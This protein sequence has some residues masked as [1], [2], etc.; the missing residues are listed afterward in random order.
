MLASDGGRLSR[1]RGNGEGSIT[2]RKDGRWMARYMIH[3]GKGPERRYIYGRTRQEVSEKLS[4]ALSD[5]TG[6]LVLDGGQETL[7][8]YLERWLDDVVRDT[9]KQTTLENY[10]YIVRLHIVP[11]LGCVRLRVS[12]GQRGTEL[13]SEEIGRRTLKPHRADYSHSPPQGSATKCA[14]RRSPA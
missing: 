1:K 2:K 8:V 3:T 12:E 7:G 13:V 4:K 6:G 14:R 10:A 9:V 5:R 11:E